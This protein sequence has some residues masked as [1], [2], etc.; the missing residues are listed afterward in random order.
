MKA[1]VD[2]IE[3]EYAVILFEDHKVKANIPLVLLPGSIREGA[4][5]TI[6]FKEDKKTTT[7][8]YEK[9]KALLE[10]LKNRSNGLLD[11]E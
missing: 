4:W 9:N 10:K 11:N 1:V 6:D 2:R 5:L 8:M 7:S 3:G